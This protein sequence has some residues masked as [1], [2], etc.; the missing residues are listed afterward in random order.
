[1]KADPTV[2]G[3]VKKNPAAL[4]SIT[5]IVS[6]PLAENAHLGLHLG[7]RPEILEVGR[8]Q[9]RLLPHLLPLIPEFTPY[10]EPFC[11][12]SAL[13]FHLRRAA[14]VLGDINPHLVR[15]LLDPAICVP[16]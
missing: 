8:K 7:A 3:S 11:G 2:R 9:S 4:A 12:S 14:A 1:L 5:D 16:I 15:T 10:I 13:Y 6:L